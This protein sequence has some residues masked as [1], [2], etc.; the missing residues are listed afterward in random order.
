MTGKADYLTEPQVDSLGNPVE[1]TQ[2]YIHLSEPLREIVA[3]TNQNSNNQY[4]EQIFRYLGSR[5]SVPATIS[6]STQL[7]SAFWKNRKLDLSSCRIEDGCGLAPTDAISPDVFVA[8]LSY[9]Y[10]SKNFA[11]F[12]ASLPV[13]GESGTLKSF[14]A[15]TDLEHRLHAKSGTISTVKAYAGYIEAENGDMWVFS[16]VINNFKGKAATAQKAIQ[17]FLNELYKEHK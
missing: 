11:D 13:A 15:K 2:L 5:M 16:I 9:M 17:N 8:L 6:N 12:Y 4:A 14:C 7:I 10:K 3:E 1:R